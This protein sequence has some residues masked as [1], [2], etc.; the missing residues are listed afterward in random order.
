MHA[1]LPAMMTVRN[2]HS[3]TTSAIGLTV[4]PVNSANS[5]LIVG[6]IVTVKIVASTAHQTISR[7]RAHVTLGRGDVASSSMSCIGKSP[8]RPIV[9]RA[10]DQVK[11]PLAGYRRGIEAGKFKRRMLGGVAEWLKAAVC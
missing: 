11:K 10:I 5:S 9:I 7:T 4:K 8:P 1:K 2:N 3:T 6:R